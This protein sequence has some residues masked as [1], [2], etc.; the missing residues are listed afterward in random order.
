MASILVEN[1]FIKEFRKKN[2]DWCI[3]KFNRINK[4]LNDLKHEMEHSEKWDEVLIM[5]VYIR[6]WNDIATCWWAIDRLNTTAMPFDQLMMDDFKSWWE[7][8]DN[9]DD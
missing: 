2:T 5:D 9:S 6:K 1:E 7:K 3:E 8:N 4:L